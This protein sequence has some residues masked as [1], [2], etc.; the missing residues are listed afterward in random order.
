MKKEFEKLQK[1]NDKIRKELD[2]LIG[3]DNP[4]RYGKI[5]DSINKLIEN[6][7][8]QEKYCG[9]WIISNMMKGC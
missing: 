7:I 8:E 3:L 1:E 5:W 4:K 6:E 9:E 2:K